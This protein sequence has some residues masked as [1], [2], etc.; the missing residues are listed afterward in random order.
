[1]LLSQYAEEEDLDRHLRCDWV[2][3]WGGWKEAEEALAE[4]H[5]DDSRSNVAAEYV[6]RF[7]RVLL[8]NVNVTTKT[9]AVRRRELELTGKQLGFGL[10]HGNNE[11]C[12]DSLLQLLVVHQYVPQYASN[13]AIRKEACKKCRAF[14]KAHTD[15]RLRP[16][17]RTATGAIADATDE[18]HDRAFLQHDVHAEPVVRFFLNHFKSR[19]KLEPCGIA[20]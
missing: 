1:M 17:Q 8:D 20:S 12:A 6:Q 2:E 9:D 11:C 3:T 5:D 19:R 13:A 14:L 4:C 16:R 15:E 10:V 7:S 18:E